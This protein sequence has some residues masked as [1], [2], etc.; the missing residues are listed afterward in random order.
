MITPGPMNT[1]VIGRDAADE[2]D[3]GELGLRAVEAEA[4]DQMVLEAEHSL[5]IGRLDRGAVAVGV[6]GLVVQLR[7]GERVRAEE[8]RDRAAAERGAGAPESEHSKPEPSLHG[9]SFGALPLVTR[10]RKLL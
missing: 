8:R 10:C 3:A 9:A 6:R 1:R 5:R 7:I 2:G 4:G